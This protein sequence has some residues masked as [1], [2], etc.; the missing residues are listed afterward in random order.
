MR[1]FKQFQ[2]EPLPPSA[3]MLECHCMNRREDCH[4]HQ[5]IQTQVQVHARSACDPP[6]LREEAP[7]LY[8]TERTARAA[9]LEA[10]L[11]R[12]RGEAT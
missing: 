10:Q 1:Q 11:R 9:E 2:T 7:H 12:L 5:T 3:A 6:A 4:G 8:E